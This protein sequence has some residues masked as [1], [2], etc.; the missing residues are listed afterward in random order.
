LG[1][2]ERKVGSNELVGGKESSMGMEDWD[3]LLLL[4]QE[5][6]ED[7]GMEDFVREGSLRQL[8]SIKFSSDSSLL[9]E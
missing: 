2:K 6:E 5:E 8:L 7:G 3:V 9:T 4:L 1:D